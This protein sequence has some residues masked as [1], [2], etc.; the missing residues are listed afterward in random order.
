MALN[1]KSFN[2]IFRGSLYRNFHK[3][4][5]TTIVA[6]DGTE[7]KAH[8]MFL[9]LRSE[10]FRTYFR[11]DIEKKNRLVVA[12][13]KDILEDILIFIYCG[14]LRLHTHNIASTII[15]ADYFQI[16][17]LLSQC[18]PFA[19][20]EI[21][22]ENCA[23]LLVASY[24]VERL[25]IAEH[26][27]RFVQ[28]HFESLVRNINSGI[29]E[30]PYCIFK[31]LLKDDS[32]CVASE[33]TVWKAIVIWVNGNKEER[34]RHV[35]ELLTYIRWNSGND[36]LASYICENTIV[37]ENV[38]C[39][40][41]DLEKY[42]S[43]SK[44]K[45]LQS[46][47][48]NTFQDRCPSK[49]YIFICRNTSPNFNNASDIYL[50]YDEKI[51]IWRKVGET[52]EDFHALFSKNSFIFMINKISKEMKA[53][54]LLKKVWIKKECMQSAR[55]AYCAVQCENSLF[56]IGGFNFM[57]INTDVECYDILKDTWK[58]CMTIPP[59]NVSGAAVIGRTLY[60]IGFPEDSE[61]LEMRALAYNTLNDVWSD[62][63]K[64]KQFRTNFGIINFRDQLYILGGR[65]EENS[66]TTSVEKYSAVNNEWENFPSLPFPY[67]LP[68]AIILQDKLMVFDDCPISVVH[69]SRFSPCVWNDEN[70]TWD[71]EMI[72]SPLNQIHMYAL[73]CI[74]DRDILL[75]LSKEN[76]DYET[77]WRKTPFVMN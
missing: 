25:G 52:D 57:M 54:D 41:I 45:M 14:E 67:E 4:C 76:K 58:Y 69:K 73:C 51:D 35:P 17:D 28:V 1:I 62:I 39:R 7:F 48:P 44:Y 49:M 8:K 68:Q 71:V 42:A 36:K 29:E 24:S 66:I 63:E 5:D 53:F 37:R 65:T 72:N 16:D 55:Q 27:Y 10:Y 33:E 15:A 34:L 13:R 18:I 21:S 19:L 75:A 2:D 23:S 30:L 31:N 74:E 38:F 9:S 40:S 59:M 70:Q 20:R 26:C 47:I 56:V 6:E 43:T 60:V 3:L 50:T 12:V 64:P 61:R 77:V 32:L 22:V 46:D 11:G